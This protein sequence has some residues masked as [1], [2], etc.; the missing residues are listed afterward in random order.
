MDAETRNRVLAG[1]ALVA[2]AG[3]G[4]RLAGAVQ[5]RSVAEI[6]RISAT[7]VSAKEAETAALSR[8][9][10]F[11]SDKE[12]FGIRIAKDLEK[13]GLAAMTVDELRQPQAYFDEL[14]KPVVLRAGRSWSSEHVSVKASTEKVRFQQR[15][16][17][18]SARHSV[19]TVKNISDSPVAYF[20][21]I[22]SGDER[23]CKARGGRMHN[24][25]ALL[26]GEVAEIAV[27]AGDG[28]VEIREVKTLEITPLGYLYFS[29]V[30]PVAVGHDAVTGQAHR[31]QA[32][33]DICTRVPAVKLANYL[34][35]EAVA[36]RDL[37][38]FYA[39]HPCDEFQF[40]A[41]YKHTSAP[42]EELPATRPTGG[43]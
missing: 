21:D 22:G 41:S 1:V 17:V 25:M 39:R 12:Y 34:R 43:Y 15:G 16:A 19:A 11:K 13:H 14:D 40:P 20:M 38:D 4:I 35:T 29:R 37:A 3:Y 24:A 9:L 26:P 27:C 30:P 18:I 5:R 2:V 42:L 10:S 28:A 6:E 33:V 36:W 32:R 23:E 7:E 8:E 31:P